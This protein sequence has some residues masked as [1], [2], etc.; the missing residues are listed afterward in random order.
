M[1][2]ITRIYDSYQQ[3]SAA[4][5]ELK[6]FGV[7][8]EL[9]HLTTQSNG[10]AGASADEVTRSVMAGWIIKSDAE[11]FAQAVLK[12]QSLVTV[13]APFGMGVD[14]TEI[15]DAHHPAESP[16]AEEQDRLQ[17]WD[18]AAPLSSALGI[19]V[20]SD[21]PTP[22]STFWH[23]PVLLKKPGTLSSKLGLPE[24][25][26]SPTPAPFSS[27]FGLPV[28]LKPRQPKR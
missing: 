7:D 11:V 15:L 21:D 22:F 25:I 1:H 3:A 19:P 4:I 6:E 10:H 17:P 5:S 20:R 27:M 13:R 9:I 23:W 18:E 16:V 26:E 28:L 8:D 2:P 14:V 24:I 12:G